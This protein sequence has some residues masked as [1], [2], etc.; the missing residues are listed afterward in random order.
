MQKYIKH[1][2]REKLE[3]VETLR[4]EFRNLLNKSNKEIE[5]LD[6]E[7]EDMNS[8][9]LHLENILSEKTPMPKE[10]KKN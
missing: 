5:A 7:L 3:E 8:E 4:E 10:R 1:L 6:M 2:K 9:L